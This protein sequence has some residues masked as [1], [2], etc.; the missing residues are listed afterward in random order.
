MELD[1]SDGAITHLSN[2]DVTMI[3]NLVGEDGVM[4]LKLIGANYS[5]LLVRDVVCGISK[6][7]RGGASVS[8]GQVLHQD[9]SAQPLEA[10]TTP[11]AP[12]AMYPSIQP[13]KGAP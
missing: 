3:T 10:T 5:E 1:N 2:Q 6:M 4:V 7:A 13:E 8:Y 11:P 12:P 9:P